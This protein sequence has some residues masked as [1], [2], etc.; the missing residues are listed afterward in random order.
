MTEPLQLTLAFLAGGVLGLFFFGGLRWTVKRGV[1]MKQPA[2][3]FLG[4]L[5]LRMGVALTGFYFVAG[6][7]WERTVSCLLGMVAVRT[8]MAG[9]PISFA[10]RQTLTARGASHAP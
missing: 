4:S 8:V 1:S 5:L 9:W 10:K 7:Q 6:G 2:L 3:W